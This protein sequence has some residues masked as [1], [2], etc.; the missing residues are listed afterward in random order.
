MRSL[1]VVLGRFALKFARIARGRASNLYEA[2]LYRSANATRRAL[3]CPV[4]WGI[5]KRIRADHEGRES[6]GRNDEHR[7]VH[8][9]DVEVLSAIAPMLRLSLS[10]LVLQT[11]VRTLHSLLDGIEAEVW[12]DYA[13]RELLQSNDV[14][15]NTTAGPLRPGP[16]QASCFDSALIQCGLTRREIE[17]A[18]A[19]LLGHSNSFMAHSL[20][21]SIRTIENH[22]RSIYAKAMVNGPNFSPSCSP[23]LVPT[24]PPPDEERCWLM[25]R[26]AEANDLR[27]TP[28]AELE[29]ERLFQ[30]AG[31]G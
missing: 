22:L 10:N 13:N 12:V 2:R 4:V 16:S 18:D 21:I 6:V 27:T 28:P 1:V 24:A 20:G 23:G 7:R 19:L 30:P 29:W 3:L 5:P 11:E 8:G 31:A 9:E 15:A 26:F 14:R 25:V 17:I